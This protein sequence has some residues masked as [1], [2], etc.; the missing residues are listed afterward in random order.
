MTPLHQL[1]QD[2]KNK[3]FALPAFNI[4]SFEIYQAV[5]AAVADT[6]LPCL[7]QLSGNEDKFIQA[8]RLFILVKK[9]Q[10]DGLPLYL[11]IDHGKDLNRLQ[12]LLELGFDMVHFDGSSLPFEENLSISKNFIDSVHKKYPEKLI[13]VEFNKIHLVDS[14]PSADSFTNPSQASHFLSETKAD[15]L[16][17]SIGNLHGVSTNL[18]ENLDLELLTA[19]SQTLPPSQLFT[20]HGGSGIDSP[21]IME[22][23][24]L[25]VVK[26]NI[27][28]E[29]RLQFRQSLERELSANKSEKIYEYFEPVI[30]DLKTLI[31]NKLHQ[32]A[33]KI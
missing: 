10:I 23:I 4:D 25:G 30:A 33:P 22:A 19:I 31:V 1:F 16:A 8:E 11:N 32:F 3:G 21:Q 15:L 12:Y 24:K 18:P 6:N 13:E 9:A 7:V 20:L 26:I 17:V 14:N 5:E 2:Y 29:L 28:T 27:N